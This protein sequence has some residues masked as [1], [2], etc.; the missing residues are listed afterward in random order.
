MVIHK[1]NIAIIGYGK[2]GKTIEKTALSRNHNVALIIDNA[3]DWQRNGA[4]L[5]SCDAA[6]EFTTPESAAGNIQKCFEE[7]VPVISG[8]T[9][10]YQQLPFIEK[11]CQ[12]HNGCLFHASNFSIGVNI[13]FALNKK[14]AGLLANLEGYQ[15]RIIETHHTE[16][17]DAPSGTAITL[18]KEI[19]DARRSLD[20][21]G[22]ASENLPPNALPV[23]S[24]RIENITGTHV[25]GYN[26]VIDSIEIKHTSHTRSGFAEG[27]IMAA[28]WLQ[29]KEGIFTMQDMLNL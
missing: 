15:P 26:S 29:N 14:L 21:W 24:Y 11:L 7:G 22:D 28:E 27:A 17:L 25:V 18:A 19:I 1:L 6:L 2:M 23:K 9:G 16:K 12:Q 8:T 10:W 20:K 5:K 3:A 4:K 13:F